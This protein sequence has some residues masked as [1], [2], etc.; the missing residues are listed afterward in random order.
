MYYFLIVVVAATDS[1]ELFME[2][3]TMFTSQSHG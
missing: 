1:K 2:C 3:V